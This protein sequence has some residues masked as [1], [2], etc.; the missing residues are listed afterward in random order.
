M[1][2][3]SLSFQKQNSF[4]F[5]GTKNDSEKSLKEQFS[6]FEFK[7]NKQVH[8][9]LVIDADQ[10][11]QSAD[12]LWTTQK[13]IAIVSI[14]ADC[15]PILMSN[16]KKAFALHAG[17]R[18]IAS[19]IVEAAFCSLSTEEKISHWTICIGPHIQKK[20]FDIK[21]DAFEALNAAWKKISTKQP[22]ADEIGPQ[23]WAFDLNA[24]V[25]AQLSFYFKNCDLINLGLDTKTDDLFHSYRRDKDQAGRNYSFVALL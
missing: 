7:K 15:T 5:F 14:T 25:A 9:N 8:S 2:N 4:F 21:A 18:G 17:W 1:N 20:S 22:P 3:P 23:H 6:S 24:L 16:G 19:N 10:S 13:N 12:G 11:P